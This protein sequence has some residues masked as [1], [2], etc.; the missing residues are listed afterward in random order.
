[1]A[2]A[3][4]DAVLV[5]RADE[6]QGEYVPRCAERLKWLTGF[7]GSAG[8]AVVG[9]T[10][11]ALFVDGRYVVQAP[12]QVDTRTFEVL[13]VPQAKLEEWLGTHLKAGGVV[14]FD[15]RLHTAAMIED[16]AKT[17]QAE[18]HQAQ[19]AGG[20]SGRPRLGARAPRP[21]AGCGD[22][23]CDEIRRQGRRAEDRRAAGGPAQG[24]RG[25]GDPDAARFHRLAAQHP[26]LRRGA[27]PGG[28]GIRDRSGKRQAGAVRRSGQDR[29]GGQGAPGGARQ[30]QRARRLSSGG[31]RRS[32][33]RASASGSIRP[34]P[35][36]GSSASS[37]AARRASCA[38]PTRACC[39]RRAR[40]RPRSRARAPPTSA[41][42][43]PWCASSPGST[44]RRCRAGST[45]SPHRAGS[46]PSAARRRR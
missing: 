45:R 37:G 43:R 30:D 19:A 32:R 14:G 10:A 38:G 21:A 35:R 41:T 46:R 36:A 2:K 15:P 9:R 16:L 26:R 33:A 40:T 3:G 17:L 34:P 29:A 6:H 28:A 39:P 25:R 11:A 1:M 42:G 24:G 23:A 31:W 13:Q 20:Q 7:S 18:G 4:L 22:P 44:A 8:L 5:P 27:Q 12:A